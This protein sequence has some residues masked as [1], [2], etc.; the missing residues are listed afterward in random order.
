MR[1]VSK[2]HPCQ[3]CGRPT[4]CGLSEDG[5]LALCM[6]VESGRPTKNRGWLHVLEERPERYS[7]PA[8]PVVHSHEPAPPRRLHAVYSALLDRLTL[9]EAHRANL[10]ERG[11]SDFDIQ[12][13]SFKSAPADAPDLS[14]FDLRGVPGFYRER[15]RWRLVS[16]G[17]GFYVP[18]RDSRGSLRGFQL[19]RDSGEPRYLWLS[20]ASKPEGASSGA[21]IHFTGPV[22]DRLLITEG[23]L[24]A[25]VIASRLGLPVLGLPGVN[26]WPQGF[27]RK[28]RKTFP[29]LSKIYLCFDSDFKTNPNVSRALFSLLAE[30]R[31]A[32][33]SPSVLT[34]DEAKGFDDYLTRKAA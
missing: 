22:S 30:L 14:D 18:V 5:S 15:G 25:D 26:T 33:Y 1:R 23:A 9:S 4:W 3:I 32:L 12:S 21:P 17:P 7:E 2:K 20:S 19:R 31:A 34:W 10:R 6:R 24:K 13:L 29:A 28:L 8:R 16:Y 11:L 27:G